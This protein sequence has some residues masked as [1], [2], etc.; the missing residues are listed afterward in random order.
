[1]G[2]YS[3]NEYKQ[4]QAAIVAAEAVRQAATAGT[5]TAAQQKAADIAFNRTALASA[6]VQGVSPAP[7]F[8]ALLE[9]GTGG[10]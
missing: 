10:S 8:T 4:H 1:M 6:K 2:N 9:L 7:F 3:F 5:P